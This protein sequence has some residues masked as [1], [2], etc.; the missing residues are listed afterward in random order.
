[1]TRIEISASRNYTVTIGSGIISTLPD[2]IRLLTKARKLC[3]ITD[4]NVWPLYGEQLQTKL[5]KADFAVC[6]FVLKPGE[7]Q[8]NGLTYLGILE[9][10]AENGLT[11]SDCIIAL[12]GGV[13]GDLAGFAAAT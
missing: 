7:E 9:Q 3:I 5:Q 1:M 2:E 4:E 8:K 6:S 11:R 10:L 12:G 13:V